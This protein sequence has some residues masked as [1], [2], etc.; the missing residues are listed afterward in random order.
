M[1]LHYSAI[2]YYAL[3]FTLLL[4]TEKQARGF[5]GE[6]CPHTTHRLISKEMASVGHAV[7]HK[8]QPKHFALSNISSPSTIRLA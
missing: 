2:P 6:V 7:T 8:P 1:L 5:G 4:L 3:K